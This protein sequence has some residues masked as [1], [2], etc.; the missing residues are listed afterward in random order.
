MDGFER[1][2]RII[3]DSEDSKKLSHHLASSEAREHKTCNRYADILPFNSTR[4]RLLG[5][6][7]DYINA[8]WCYLLKSILL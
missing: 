1:E 2:F 5:G 6:D 4:V 8:V 7:H 3:Q